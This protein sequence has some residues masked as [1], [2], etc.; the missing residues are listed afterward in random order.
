M[1]AGAVGKRFSVRTG[2]V[3]QSSKLDYQ[4]WAIAIDQMRAIVQG[5]D[6]KRLKYADLVADAA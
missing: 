2:T 4:T 5:M 6:W 3:M 1:V